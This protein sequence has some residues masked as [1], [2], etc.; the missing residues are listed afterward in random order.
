[1]SV[2]PDT[3]KPAW[4]LPEGHSQTLWRKFLP[5]PEPKHCR[6]RIELDD[7]DF[8]DIDWCT[9]TATR[10]QSSDR[11]VVLIHGLCGCSQSTYIVSLQEHLARAELS[12][13][14]VNLRGCS[15]EANRLA[16]SYHSGVSDDLDA[17]YRHLHSRYPTR[18]LCFVGFSLGGNVLL[19]WL[20][21]NNL[22]DSAVRRAVAV[23]T[24][25]QLG[26]CSQA[27]TRGLSRIYGNYFVNRLS[28]A[29][30]AKRVALSESNKGD[31]LA[32]LEAIGEFSGFNNIWEFDERVTAPLNGFHDAQHYYQSCSSG[33]LLSR[34]DVNTLLIQSSDDPLIPVA[35]VPTRADLA[36]QVELRLLRKGG[37]VGFVSSSQPNWLEQQITQYLLLD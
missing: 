26:L 10:E 18:Q 19:K 15:G 32:R 33:P 9:H 28:E 21:E 25:F 13:V 6:D 16:R 17:V 4:W 3:F 22:A 29:F 2:S 8:L 20:G 11:I 31:E 34:I 1:M 35:A 37:H 24:P 14:A 12:S 30:A 5:E 7:G 27:M 23:S 36:S